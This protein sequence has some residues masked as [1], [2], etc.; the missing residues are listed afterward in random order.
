[1]AKIILEIDDVRYVLTPVL[2]GFGKSSCS[3]CDIIECCW[4]N[5]PGLP[6]NTFYKKL[7]VFKREGQGETK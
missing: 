3:N 4:N 2:G 1:M 6:C 7:A 5:F